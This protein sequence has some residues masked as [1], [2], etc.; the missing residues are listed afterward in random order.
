MPLS[1]E[2]G[3]RLDAVVDAL[4]QSGR[5]HSKSEV[6]REGVRLV[7][8]REV[9]LKVLDA[10]LEA[11]LQDIDAGRVHEADAVFDMLRRRFGPTGP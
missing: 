2:L 1:V 5:Y 10:A 7:Q 11:G 6:L 8:E 9:K 4:V 3:E